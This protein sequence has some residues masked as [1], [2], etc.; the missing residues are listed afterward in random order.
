MRDRLVL[1]DPAR[2]AY[3]CVRLNSSATCTLEVAVAAIARPNDTTPP[4]E[5]WVEGTLPRYVAIPGPGRPVT[6]GLPVF[7]LQDDLLGKPKWRLR[8]TLRSLV[9][10]FIC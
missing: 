1:L 2:M 9:V 5:G 8:S 3:A 10:G 7:R 4:A 6:A